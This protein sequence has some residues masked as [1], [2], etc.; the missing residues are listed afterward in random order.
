MKDFL[1]DISVEAGRISLDY[2]SKLSTLSVHKKSAKDLVTE[3][4]TAVEAFL[5]EQIRKRYPEHSLLGEE[6]GAHQGNEYRWII[7]PIDGTTSFLHGQPFYSISIAL[8]KAGRVVLGGVNAPVLDELFLAERGRGAT[9]NGVAIAV[10]PRARLIDSVLGTGFACIRADH[11]H[12]NLPYFSQVVGK[13]RGIRRYGSC[14]IDLS[15]VACGLLEGFWELNLKIYDM[16]AGGLILEEAGGKLSDFTG[17][18]ARVP[19]ELVATNGFIHDDMVTLLT[20]VRTELV[21]AGIA[22]P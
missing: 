15:Y 2:R 4:D 7:D 3:A 5:F 19:G 6:A 21:A 14:A 18:T 17:T 22:Q 9:R 13:I 12:N 20:E 8:E 10:S 11:E 16:A 1:R